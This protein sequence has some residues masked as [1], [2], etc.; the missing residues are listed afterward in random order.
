ML[1]C[2]VLPHYAITKFVRQ[3][4]RLRSG[5]VASNAVTSSIGSS[6]AARDEIGKMK[7]APDLG[8]QIDVFHDYHPFATPWIDH[9]P[10]LTHDAFRPLRDR[11]R[12]VAWRIVSRHNK[13]IVNRLLPRSQPYIVVVAADSIVK[14]VCTTFRGKRRKT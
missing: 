7:L 14:A 5:L 10:L 4:L 12:T 1:N 13:L 2:L 3:I 8:F 6:F 11:L 9:A